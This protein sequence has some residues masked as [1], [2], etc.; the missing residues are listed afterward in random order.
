MHHSSWELRDQLFLTRLLPEADQ[1]DLQAMTTTS[2][3]LAEGTRCSVETQA[4][5][6][7]L[8][9]YVMEF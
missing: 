9:A 3:Y 8:L 7:L 2:Q 4:A 6:T 5:A 1:V